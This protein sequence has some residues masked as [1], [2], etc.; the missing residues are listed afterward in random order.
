MHKR[1][2]TILMCVLA[3]SLSSLGASKKKTVATGAPDKAYLQKLMDGWSAGNPANMAQYYDQGD[4][5]FFDIV[6]LKYNNWAEYQKGVEEVLKGY[7]SFKLTVN[8]DAQMHTDGNL[9]WAAA[10]LKED[11]ITAAGKHELA[12]LRWTVIFEKQGGKWLIVHEH[13]SEPLP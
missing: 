5:T 1:L 9:T 10:T 3:L 4:Y 13:T 7:K 8:D 2:L 6:P 12:T 11:A